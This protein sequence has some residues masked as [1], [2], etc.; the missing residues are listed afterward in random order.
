MAE[1]HLD[2]RFE[3]YADPAELRESDQ[4]LLR[5]AK[6]A[7]EDAYAPYSRFRVGAAVRLA[8]GS[9]LS[10]FNIENAAY[11]M[12]ICAEQA[13]LASAE[14][15]FPG[16]AIESIAISV[17]SEHQVVHSPA[18]PCGA[19]RQVLLEKELR[20]G[21]PV[22]II[23]QGEQGPILVFEAAAHL[24]PFYFDGSFL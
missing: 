4:D 13:T 8:N 18:A 22:R 5:E 21:N 15:R 17:R 24:L 2:I 23:L 9:I 6:R 14:T 3:T 19:C 10:G 12:C 7:L 1:R 11:P 20:Q 16:M